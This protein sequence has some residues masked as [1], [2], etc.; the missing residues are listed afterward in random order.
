MTETI[1]KLNQFKKETL[2]EF[3][4][5]HGRENNGRPWDTAEWKER[6][7][8]VIDDECAWCGDSGDDT[9]LQIHH[10]NDPEFSWDH[11][12]IATEDELF[13]QS[14][15]FD[16]DYVSDPEHCPNCYST[17][18]YSRKTIAPTF[19]CRKC[20]YE[21]PDETGVRVPDLVSA[22][23]ASV[24]AGDGFYKAKLDWVQDNVEAI[25][26]QFKVVYDAHWEKYLSM[27]ET[28]T[29]C[30]GCHYQHHHTNK[31]LCNRCENGLGSY[32]REYRGYLC[33]DCTVDEKGLAICLE[34][35]ENWH[36]PSKTTACS[37]C[38]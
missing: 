28:V 4:D 10:Y 26:E 29:I 3:L 24:Y 16:E 13:I 14:D 32:D 19:R 17:N 18:F 34:C 25:K 1:S 37:D 6:R 23:Y 36:D 31:D 22:S 8:E 12:W 35:G 5:E 38:R 15:S 27:E 20:E 7:E 21:F 2:S 9:T 11:E 30:Q 33:W